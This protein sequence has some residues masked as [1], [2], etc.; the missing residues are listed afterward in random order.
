MAN[1]RQRRCE[2]TDS[3]R[4]QYDA[5]IE[6]VVLK[7]G[8]VLRAEKSRRLTPCSREWISFGSWK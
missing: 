1:E 7:D 6:N 5:D 4:W 8:V 3:Q 2:R